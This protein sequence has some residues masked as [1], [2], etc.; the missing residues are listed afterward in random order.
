MPGPL[1]QGRRRCGR[2]AEGPVGRPGGRVPPHG[3]LPRRAPE[4][5]RRPRRLEAARPR[6]LARP[7]RGRRDAQQ[8]AARRHARTGRPRPLVPRRAGRVRAALRGPAPVARP[9]HVPPGAAAALRPGAAGRRCAGRPLL[10]QPRLRHHRLPRPRPHAA[11]G[12]VRRPAGRH[13]ARDR[14]DRPHRRR[15]AARRLRRR[16][17]HRRS[18]RERGPARA[19]APDSRPRAAGAGDRFPDGLL[20]PDAAA[21]GAEGQAVGRAGAD[22]RHAARPRRQRRQRRPELAA[23][24]LEGRPAP[25]R[26]RRH[27]P[28][29]RPPE[30]PRLHRPRQRIRRRAVPGPERR[31]REGEHRR[32]CR[33]RERPALPGGPHALLAGRRRPRRGPTAGRR[34]STPC[35][36]RPACATWPSDSSAS[37]R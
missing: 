3:R 14:R 4:A 9:R 19:P 26:L 31:I 27:G 28:L 2:L 37:C 29:L 25:D 6:R 11:A 35:A 17:P 16:A 8:H 1:P 34:S 5:L 24:G 33:A 20:R 13:H 12:R 32:P 23:D 30:G 21:D 15:L 18:G 10:H 36:T 22:A 7:H